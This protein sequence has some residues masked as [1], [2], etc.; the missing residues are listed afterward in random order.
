MI[1]WCREC[2]GANEFPRNWIEEKDTCRYC[3]TAG[4]WRTENQPKAEYLLSHNDRRF[5]RSLRIK[6]E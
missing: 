6:A 4:R 3:K 5:L 2:D 1:V